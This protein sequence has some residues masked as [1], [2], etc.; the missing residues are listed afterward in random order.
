MRKKGRDI[1]EGV[2]TQNIVLKEIFRG[3]PFRKF[4]LLFL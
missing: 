4:V 1:E 2:T 3:L